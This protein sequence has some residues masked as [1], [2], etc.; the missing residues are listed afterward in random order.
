MMGHVF[1][2]YSRRDVAYAQR[3]ASWLRAG[4]VEPWIDDTGVDYGSRYTGRIRDAID[5]CDA[6]VVIMT[7]AAED[8]EWVEREI[9][10]ANLKRKAIYPLLL[11]GDPFMLLG[12]LHYE[13]VS[14]GSLP[15][16][17][18]LQAFA[19]GPG[20]DPLRPAE[21]GRTP[22]SKIQATDS[23][24]IPAPPGWYH[25]QGDR[26]G[27]ERYWDGTQWLGGP[28]VVSYPRDKRGLPSGC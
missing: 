10:R 7:P 8:S 23:R 2:S 14:D 6:L 27:T 20:D 3:L 9:H 24:V 26:A 19:G 22:T 1:V 16:H 28:W 15:P 12:N 4:G 21:A 25:A 18:F 11:A 17:R 5:T 13:D